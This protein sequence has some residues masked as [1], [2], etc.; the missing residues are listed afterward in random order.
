ML[1]FIFPQLIV[2]RCQPLVSVKQQLVSFAHATLRVYDQTPNQAS[3]TFSLQVDSLFQTSIRG[4]DFTLLSLSLACEASF[5][6]NSQSFVYLLKGVLDPAPSQFAH[7]CHSGPLSTRFHLGFLISLF[8]FI[9]HYTAAFLRPF[10]MS[11]S[12]AEGSI[13]SDS[14]A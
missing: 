10:S 3:P 13:A 11:Y 2:G 8:F 6:A 9:P 14:F 1:D 5:E 7:C 4:C 12:C